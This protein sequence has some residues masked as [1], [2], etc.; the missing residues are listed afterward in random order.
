MPEFDVD[1][2]NVPPLVKDM[3]LKLRDNRTPLNIKNNYK[4]ML[5]NIMR[6]CQEEINHFLNTPTTQQ[7]SRKK[8]AARRSN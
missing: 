4:L 8:S 7:S 2:Y 1:K 6:A 3:I 5:E